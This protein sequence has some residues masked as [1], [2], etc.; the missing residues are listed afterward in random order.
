MCWLPYMSN[1]CPW[2][3]SLMWK[4]S[5]LGSNLFSSLN[6]DSTFLRDKAW[7]F[8]NIQLVLSVECMK[9]SCIQSF[10]NWEDLEYLCD[11][12][13]LVI[14]SGLFFLF[15]PLLSVPVYPI[16]LYIKCVQHNTH[17]YF[18]LPFHI[19][20]HASCYLVTKS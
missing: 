3:L 2:Q 1:Q 12:K 8:R 17:F 7:I 4:C 16:L 6:K 14:F 11:E 5:Q 13:S 15:F 20:Q 18:L 19:I 10:G 9:Y